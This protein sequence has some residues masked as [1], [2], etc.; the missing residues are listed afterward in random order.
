MTMLSQRVKGISPSAT[1]AISTKAKEM[2]RQGIDVIAFGG[3]PTD[4]PEQIK[5]ADSGDC[6]GFTKY[7]RLGPR[8]EAICAKHWRI[9]DL[10]IIRMK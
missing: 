8:G 7:S 10:N 1:M 4:T 5:A 2:K 3:E 6:R 9:T